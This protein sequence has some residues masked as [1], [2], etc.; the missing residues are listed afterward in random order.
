MHSVTFPG[1]LTT[2]WQKPQLSRF[3]LIW[4]S[5]VPEALWKGCRTGSQNPTGCSKRTKSLLQTYEPLCYLLKWSI[6][7]L[8]PILQTSTK[9]AEP[10]SNRSP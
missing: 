7:K 5:E 6:R 8:I 1:Q 9:I 10:F 4:S 2:N 3:R